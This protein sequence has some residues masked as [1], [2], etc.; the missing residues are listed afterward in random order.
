MIQLQIDNSVCQ[1]DGL[2]PEHFQAI[3]DLMSYTETSGRGFSM[4]FGCKRHLMGKRGAFPTGLLYILEALL[5]KHALKFNKVDLRRR[6]KAS[7][8]MF[9]LDLGE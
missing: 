3:R 4:Q 8:G 5:K 1:V 9:N 2:P 7:Q 6:P